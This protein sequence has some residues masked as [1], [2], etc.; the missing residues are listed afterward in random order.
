MVCSAF[1]SWEK[2]GISSQL[3]SRVHIHVYKFIINFLYNVTVIESNVHVSAG[4]NSDI[5]RKKFGEIAQIDSKLRGRRG[6]LRSK[7]CD[8]L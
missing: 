7:L 2:L 6:L 3:G 4:L 1:T 8:F 5:S